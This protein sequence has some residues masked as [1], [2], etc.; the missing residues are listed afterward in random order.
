MIG[1]IYKLSNIKHVNNASNSSLNVPLNAGIM[2]IVIII[3]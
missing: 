1:N 3:L 2:Q